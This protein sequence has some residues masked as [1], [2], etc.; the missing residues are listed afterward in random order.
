M[1]RIGKPRQNTKT[2]KKEIGHQELKP[3]R[4]AMK[5]IIFDV[6]GV[7][8]SEERYFDVSGLT[9]WEWLYSSGYMGLAAEQDDFRPRP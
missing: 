7:L 8:F 4:S 5:K 3:F 2:N 1:A 9:V 6:D